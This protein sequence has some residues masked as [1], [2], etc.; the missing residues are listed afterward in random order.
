MNNQEY[1]QLLRDTTAAIHNEESVLYVGPNHPKQPQPDIYFNLPSP[2]KTGTTIQRASYAL[3][4]AKNFLRNHG[5]TE[6]TIF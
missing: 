6:P 3:Q 5:I 4:A 2:Q 1:H